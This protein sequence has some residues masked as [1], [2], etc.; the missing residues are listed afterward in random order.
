MKYL[1]QLKHVTRPLLSL[2]VFG[3]GLAAGTVEAGGRLVDTLQQVKP[4]IVAVGTFMPK[5]SPRA[6][7]RGTGFA[8]GNGD[9]IATN[10]HVLPNSLNSAGMERL[11]V[12]IKKNGKDSLYFAQELAVDSAHDV[13]VL[14]LEKG[15]LPPLTLSTDEVREGDLYAFTGYPIGMVLGLYPVTHRGIISA[16]SPVAIP[17]INSS[18]LNAKVVKRLRQ[19]YLVYQLD[20]TAYPGNSGSPLYHPGNGKVIG[21]INKVFVKETKENV[22]SKPSGIS[23]AIP[24]VHLR[25]L[26]KN[27]NLL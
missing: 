7:F 3:V 8:I 14:K 16:I 4:G 9:L 11:A 15:S 22:L 25:K 2:V 18:Q 24:I 23:Y 6:E 12:F 5:R 19:P 1:A 13:A 17:M 21:I 27:Y 20:A 26:L 10:A